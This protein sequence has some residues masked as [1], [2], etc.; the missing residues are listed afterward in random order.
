MTI[1]S[2]RPTSRPRARWASGRRPVSTEMKMMLSMPSTI[3]STVNVRNASQTS[4]SVRNSI[5]PHFERKGPA[6]NHNAAP[7]RNLACTAISVPAPEY[8][9]YH[10]EHIHSPVARLHGQAKRTQIE[11]AVF[12][13]LLAHLDERKD[14]QNI[15]LM[16]LAGFCRNC[17]AKWYAAAADGSRRT[18]RLR[19]FAG[20]RLRHAVRRVEA[21]LSRAKPRR[22]KLAALAKHDH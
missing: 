8:I 15:D 21:P 20:T 22:S 14:V 4:G 5:V 16:N 11:A 12:R 2:A 18:G 3:S 7:T 1:A 6:F 10:V 9:G 19:T 13:R 17:L